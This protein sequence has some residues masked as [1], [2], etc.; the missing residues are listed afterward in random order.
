M[1][2]TKKIRVYHCVSIEVFTVDRWEDVLDA[3]DDGRIFADI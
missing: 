3:M 2:Y 1:I